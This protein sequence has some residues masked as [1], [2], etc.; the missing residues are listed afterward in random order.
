[1]HTPDREGA[2]IGNLSKRASEVVRALEHSPRHLWTV[3]ELAKCAPLSKSQL[4]R[5]HSEHLGLGPDALIWR[6][7]LEHMKHLLSTQHL[8]VAVAARE[9]GWS[10]RSAASRAFKRQYA[11]SPR[12]QIHRDHPRL[13]APRH[14]PPRLRRRTGQRIPRRPRTAAGTLP[15]LRRDA[16]LT[17]PVIRLTS[18]KSGTGPGCVPAR[19]NPP[20]CGHRDATESSP[21]RSPQTL[22]RERRSPGK[23]RTLTWAFLSG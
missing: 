5:I 20:T 21:W 19:G 6:T 15:N 16:A 7:R 23:K 10:S 4:T 18:R 9:S 12:P 22:G 17:T 14:S 11:M 1:M 13:S 2:K 3:D 8:S